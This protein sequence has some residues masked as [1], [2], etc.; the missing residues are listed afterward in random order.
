MLLALASRVL[1]HLSKCVHN[2][3]GAQLRYEHFL[4]EHSHGYFTQYLQKKNSRKLTRYIF[5]LNH[6]ERSHWLNVSS[7]FSRHTGARL[8][9][10]RCT[11][12]PYKKRAKNCQRFGDHISNC[13][14]FMSFFH[15]GEQDFDRFNSQLVS[16]HFFR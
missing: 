7:R 1:S 3:I 9:R 4:L 10:F 16:R 2:S 5:L 6:S 14:Y 15:W 12:S 8:S 13:C 11:L